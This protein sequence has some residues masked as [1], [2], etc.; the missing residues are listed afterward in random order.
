MKKVLVILPNSIGGE[1]VLI[2]FAQGFK[3]NGCYVLKKDIRELT[4]Q[5]VKNFKP[6]IIFGYDYSFLYSEDETLKNYIKEKQNEI[7][8]IHYFADIPYEKFACVNKPQLYEEFKQ[9]KALSYIW[10]ET[11]IKSLPN[12]RYLPMAIN[13]KSY[14]AEENKKYPITFV[15]RPLDDKRQ[16]ILAALIKKFGSKVNIFSYETHFL[17]SIENIKTKNLLNEKEIQ[18]YKNAYKGYLKTEQDLANI[19]YNSTVN[20]NITIQ[21]EAGLNHRVFAVLASKGFLLTDETKDIHKYFVNSKELEV[22]KNIDELLDKTEFYLKNQEIA[23]RIGLWGFAKVA[24]SHNYTARVHKI[25][26]DIK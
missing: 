22:Y 17:K 23:Q 21:G 11:Y 14:N 8:L 18:I 12:C 25:L 24:K 2:G 15:G 5:D 4:T 26:N 9:I 10:D 20:I 16:E 1:K 6:D 13:Y 7:K 19:F 3:A